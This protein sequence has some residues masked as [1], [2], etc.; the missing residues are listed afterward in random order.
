MSKFGRVHDDVVV[1]APEGSLRWR[2]IDGKA[3]VVLEP[4]DMYY[5]AALALIVFEERFTNGKWVTT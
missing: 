5:S 1:E 4:G 3:W 2:T